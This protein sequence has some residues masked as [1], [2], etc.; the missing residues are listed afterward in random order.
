M[1]TMLG[2]KQIWAIFLLEFKIDCKAAETTCNINNNFGPGTANE[3]T[4]QWWFQKFCTGDESLEDECNGRPSEVDN[5]EPSSKLILLQ[6]HKKLPKNSVLTITVIQPLKQIRKVKKFDKWVPQEL[7]KNQKNHRFEVLSSLPR[8]NNSEP[9]LDWI[10]TCDKNRILYN[11]QLSGWTK[12]LQSTSQSQTCTK[13]RSRSLFGHLLL[14]WSMKAFWIPVKPLHLRSMLSKLMRCT[15]KGM[16][17]H[18][19]ILAWGILWTEESGGLQSTGSQRADTT[20]QLL[21]ILSQKTA[22]PA[23]SSGQQKGADFSPQPLTTCHTTDASK[24]EQIVLQSFASSA[25]FTWPL[26]NWLLLLQASRELFEGKTLLQ[27]AGGRKCFPKFH[28]ILKHK[29][30]SYRNE[31]TY[32]SLAKMCWL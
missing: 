14:V 6:L 30:L 11:N 31:Q 22:T 13:K 32:F 9:F 15:K 28:W 2:K 16:A 23:A 29:F 27:P 24:V 26:A 5:Q 8:C 19:S 7:T 20:E 10:M 18:S 25:I 21:L 12:K 3:C 17:T 1:E 4:V